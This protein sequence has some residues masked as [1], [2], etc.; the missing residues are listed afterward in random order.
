[1]SCPYPLF[2]ASFAYLVVV[3]IVVILCCY[4]GSSLEPPVLR[5]G[6]R[7]YV[8]CALFRIHACIIFIY[9]CHVDPPFFF[10][11]YVYLL[12]ISRYCSSDIMLV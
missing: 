11:F 7:G 6:P 10:L 3:V 2:I 8:C 5:P 4:K 1:M 9:M 12:C